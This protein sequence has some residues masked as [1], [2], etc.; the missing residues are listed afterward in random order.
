MQPKYHKGRYVMISFNI[1]SSIGA[2]FNLKY[3]AF[4][5]V[6]FDFIA[7]QGSEALVQLQVE[8][9][10]TV[11]GP[12]ILSKSVSSSS[13]QSMREIS[14]QNLT[15]PASQHSWIMTASTE[16]RRE[17]SLKEYQDLLYDYGSLTMR[18]IIC[19]CF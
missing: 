6:I 9:M 5:L 1:H 17:E 2:I 8:H 15:S 3:N 10:M 14:Y 18:A 16:Y 19:M 13:W 4:M 11:P 12:S 7:H